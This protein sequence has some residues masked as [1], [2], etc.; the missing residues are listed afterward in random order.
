MTRTKVSITAALIAHILAWAAT[1]FFLFAHLRQ[2]RHTRRSQRRPR[3]TATRHPR[4]PHRRRPHC[5]APQ[6]AAPPPDAH[7]PLGIIR[8]AARLP[9]RKR[10]VNRNL[11]PPR[12]RSNACRS[13]YWTK[14]KVYLLI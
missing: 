11:L 1:L 2:R 13:D 5:I 7:P 6:S 8:P 3:G 10:A 12:R 14:I 9:R 4:R